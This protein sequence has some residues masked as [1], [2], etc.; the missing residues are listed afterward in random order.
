MIEDNVRRRKL[1]N[2]CVPSSSSC[3]PHISKVKK[4]QRVLTVGGH[5]IVSG[6]GL[7]FSFYNFIQKFL[8]FKKIII[9]LKY[10][11]TYFNPMSPTSKLHLRR[12]CKK[13]ERSSFRVTNSQQY[14]FII[15]FRNVTR[16]FNISSRLVSITQA[17]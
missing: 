8:I 6:Y 15:F 4:A 11:F 2:N 17:H 5:V 10:N 7:D 9:I 14:F 16:H 3:C 1:K 13:R 12:R